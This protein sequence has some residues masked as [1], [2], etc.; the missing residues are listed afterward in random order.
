M[1]HHIYLENQK[2]LCYHGEFLYEAKVVKYHRDV[3]ESLSSETQPEIQYLVHY[4]GWNKTWDE[5]VPSSRLMPLTEDNLVKQRT[6][7][8]KYEKKQHVVDKQK[9]KLKKKIPL[10][11]INPEVSFS[12]VSNDNSQLPGS[13]SVNLGISNVDSHTSL[14]ANSSFI[15]SRISS[16]EVELF[17][18]AS[19]LSMTTSKSRN[20]LALQEKV[21]LLKAFEV[22]G[23]V[24]Q[25]SVAVK[26]GISTS[27]VSR[28]VSLKDEIFEQFEDSDNGMRKR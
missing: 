26:Y 19:Q 23:R 8:N 11:T 2:V 21:K 12:I 1:T 3:Q 14:H 4:N 6:L 15:T 17:P 16:P 27:H 7:F 9:I 10:T 13:N 22:G 18:S 28:L 5:W 24:T 25:K 20:D